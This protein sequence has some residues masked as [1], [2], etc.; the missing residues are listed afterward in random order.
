M[1]G[2]GRFAIGHR[3]GRRRSSLPVDHVGPLQLVR[4][5]MDG[6]LH[7]DDRAGRV[8]RDVG[9]RDGGTSLTNATLVTEQ[10]IWSTVEGVDAAFIDLITRRRRPILHRVQPFELRRWQRSRRN[11]AARSEHAGE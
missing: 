8:M 1:K 2:V 9:G 11:G 7:D 4:M 10:R 6:A 5:R 3:D